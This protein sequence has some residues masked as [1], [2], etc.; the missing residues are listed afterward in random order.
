MSVTSLICRLESADLVGSV[1]VPT[2]P[3][4]PLPK[5]HSVEEVDLPS[6]EE[7]HLQSR[8]QEELCFLLDPPNKCSRVVVIMVSLHCSRNPN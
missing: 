7:D 2:T 1:S 6:V 3:C 8:V 4:V 5:L